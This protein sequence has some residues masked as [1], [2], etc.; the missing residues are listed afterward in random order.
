MNKF[1]IIDGLDRFSL[2]NFRD[3]ELI[4]DNIKFCYH[5]HSTGR[6]LNIYLEDGEDSLHIFYDTEWFSSRYDFN[7]VGKKHGY[8]VDG[9]WIQIC[10]N[11]F[12]KFWVEIIKEKEKREI[13]EKV[14]IKEQ[15]L[16]QKELEEKFRKKYAQENS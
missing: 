10:E 9:P 15:E 8:L 3:R 14:R 4:E 6:H 12:D 7:E 11:K 1:D 2:R 16:K 5:R 13:C